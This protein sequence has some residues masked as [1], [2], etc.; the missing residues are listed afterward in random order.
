MRNT[1]EVDRALERGPPPSLLADLRSAAADLVAYREVLWQL[2]LRDLRIRYKQTA[3]GV[4]WAVLTPI[5]VVLSAWILRVAFGR[6]SGEVISS[7]VLSGIAV[8]SL[9]WA[10]FVGALGFGTPSITANLALVT[11]TF[12]PREVLPLASVAT[13]L[14]DAA[15]GAVA[16]AIALPFFGVT[17]AAEQLWA[18]P[19]VVLFVLF[20]TAIT[21]LAACANVF[22]RDARHLIQLILSFGIFFTPVFFEPAALGPLGAKLLALNPLTPLLEGLRL[23]LVEHHDLMTPLLAADGAALLWS[24]GQLAYAASWALGGVAASVVVFRRAE[25]AYAEYV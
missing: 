7:P 25:F 16:L 5:V 19:L 14:A 13:Q 8:K 22:F 21:L 15:I 10:F 2:T 4:A 6:A 11:K 3:V 17:L 18:L 9:A 23:A 24:P 1:S 20:T 12:F